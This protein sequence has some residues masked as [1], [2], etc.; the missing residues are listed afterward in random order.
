MSA[1]EGVKKILLSG[2]RATVVMQKGKALDE[3]K[4][5]DALGSKKLKFVSMEIV[6]RAIPKAMFNMKA[7]G[8]T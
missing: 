7:K 8:V 4:V 5:R 2:L 3:A 1:Q 6:E